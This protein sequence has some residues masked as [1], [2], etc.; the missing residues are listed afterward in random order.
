MRRK[1]QQHAM[2]SF[3]GSCNKPFYTTLPGGDL[4]AD[5]WGAEILS[6]S[7]AK[8]AIQPD[9]SIQEIKRLKL[10]AFCPHL[11]RV[12]ECTNLV[13]DRLLF[14]L[15]C[16]LSSYFVFSFLQSSPFKLPLSCQHAPISASKWSFIW[17]LTD[18]KNFP[19]HLLCPDCKLKVAFTYSALILL[20]V[21]R[22][23]LMG[24]WLKPLGTTLAHDPGSSHT[25]RRQAHAHTHTIWSQ[26]DHRFHINKGWTA[27][28]VGLS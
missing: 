20:E 26:L 23:P 25:L 15:S 1:E 18:Y 12:R 9:S 4:V 27:Q 13:N 3:A 24:C 10:N 6:P 28:R 8:G 2:G 22:S 16:I 17:K 21:S 5:R 14:F 7:S 11:K 19:L